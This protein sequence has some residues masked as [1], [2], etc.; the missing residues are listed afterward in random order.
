[1]IQH[2]SLGKKKADLENWKDCCPT[3]YTYGS[4]KDYFVPTTTIASTNEI[5]ELIGDP[6]Q[7]RD[8]ADVAETDDNETVENDEENANL[9]GNFLHSFMDQ[10][11]QEHELDNRLEVNDT[12]YSPEEKQSASMINDPE[13]LNDMTKYIL[14]LSDCVTL[15]GMDP[16]LD[17]M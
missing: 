4:D 15:F 13:R 11:L 3:N 2:G 9:F 17:I 1:M 14:Q 6:S 10:K 12:T 8:S 7:T 16:N 5:K